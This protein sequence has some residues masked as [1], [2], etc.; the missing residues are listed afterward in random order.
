MLELNLAQFA[1]SIFA[2]KKVPTGISECNYLN[3]L[4]VLGRSITWDALLANPKVTPF[5]SSGH[6]SSRMTDSRADD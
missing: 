2:L 4:Y 5:T 3:E 1:L 6:K